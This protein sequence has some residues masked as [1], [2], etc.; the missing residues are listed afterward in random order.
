MGSEVS[1][2]CNVKIL[3]VN[4]MQRIAGVLWKRCV[5]CGPGPQPGTGKPGNCPPGNFCK[6]DG[7]HLLH[8]KSFFSRL[9]SFYVNFSIPFSKLTNQ[10]TIFPKTP[11][12]KPETSFEALIMKPIH[13]FR[14]GVKPIHPF[15]E[16]DVVIVTSQSRNP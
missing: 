3:I 4:Q 8:T 16:G 7:V 9:C 1:Y 6:H 12:T 11:N 14:E 10:C 5:T 2:N 15:H 13:P